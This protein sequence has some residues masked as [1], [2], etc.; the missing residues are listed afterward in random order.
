MQNKSVMSRLSG[1]EFVTCRT[2]PGPNQ[3]L[4]RRFSEGTSLCRVNPE[5]NSAA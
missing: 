4:D 3:P 1:R 5:L 2:F